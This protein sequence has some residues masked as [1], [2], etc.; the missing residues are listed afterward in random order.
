MYRNVTYN[1][2]K[3][4]GWIGEI[5]LTTW[6]NKG[7]PIDYTIEHQSYLYYQDIK[8]KA[9]SWFGDDIK[10]KRFKSVI[11]RYKW[12]RSEEHTSELQSH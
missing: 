11:D 9:K 1:V 8:G 4:R 2:N 7:K 3:D 5:T 6:D 12:L 10:I